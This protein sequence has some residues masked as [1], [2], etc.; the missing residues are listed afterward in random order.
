MFASAA[1][2]YAQYLV[3]QPEATPV[4]EPLPFGPSTADAPP[5]PPYPPPNMGGN[6]CNVLP[7]NLPNASTEP[8]KCDPVRWYSRVEY[9]HWWMRPDKLEQTFITTSSTPSLVDNFGAIGQSGTKI[10]SG[11][12]FANGGP[13]DGV[14]YTFGLNPECFIP[15]EFTAFYVHTSGS[16]FIGSDATGS[17]VLARPIFSLDPGVLKE[18]VYL[19]SFPAVLA[20]GGPLA[21]RQCRYRDQHRACMAPS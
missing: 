18:S 8:V 14:R 5:R 19:S 2:A 7:D 11:G 20:G 6:G 13:M 17:P 16:T 12:D 15:V 21:T 9:L 1:P 3:N 10:L 4:V